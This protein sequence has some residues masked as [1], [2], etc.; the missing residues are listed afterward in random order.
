MS[1]RAI[2]IKTGGNTGIADAIV[3]GML[4]KIA[5]DNSAELAEIRKE[6][7]RL[8]ARQGVR[9]NADDLAWAEIK[10]DLDATYA[11][12][13]H[14]VVY[15]KVLLVWALLWEKIFDIARRLQAWNREG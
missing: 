13:T 15:D 9:Q 12:K 14:G 1:G 4:K 7:D 10:A 3:D 2:V 6:N 5:V 8:K 11:I